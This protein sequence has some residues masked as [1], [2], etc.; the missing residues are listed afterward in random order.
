VSDYLHSGISLYLDQ[1]ID[2]DSYFRL[3]KGDDVDAQSEREAL[4]TV[5]ETMAEI[6]S[7]LEPQCREEWD[8]APELVD[9][10]VIR[11]ARIERA[12]SE[13]HYGLAD[14]CGRRH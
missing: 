13:F 5:L 7:N 1:L 2:W 14:G 4:G 6:C 11:P 12:V 10:K 3:K 9:G 8:Q